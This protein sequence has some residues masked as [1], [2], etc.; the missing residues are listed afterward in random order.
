ML[1][2]LAIVYLPYAIPFLIYTL[3]MAHCSAAIGALAV[4]LSVAACAM[5][6]RVRWVIVPALL[7]LSYGYTIFFDKVT[8]FSQVRFTYWSKLLDHV[9]FTWFGKGIGSFNN[10]LGVSG[11]HDYEIGVFVNAHNFLIQWYYEMGVVGVLLILSYI[12]YMFKLLLRG[13]HPKADYATA[14][15]V[16]T[17]VLSCLWQPSMY[18][19]EV[20]IPLLILC[21]VLE[22]RLRNG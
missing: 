17:G 1:I 9:G 10:I 21:I 3:V 5:Y 18:K 20:G 12:A 4:G 11:V 8:N 7:A 16:I 15:A 14:A 13:R 6:K 2:P 19:V 22:R